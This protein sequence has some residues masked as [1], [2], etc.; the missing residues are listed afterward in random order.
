MHILKSRISRD[1]IQPPDCHA[2]RTFQTCLVAPL[3]MKPLKG[4]CRGL[5]GTARTGV[6][7]ASHDP[8]R[9][10]RPCA[11]GP[12]LQTSGLPTREP[13]RADR[14]GAQRRVRS[15]GLSSPQTRSDTRRAPLCGSS[16]PGRRSRSTG[17]SS[18]ETARFR[19]SANGSQ[20]TR[21]RS[22]TRSKRRIRWARSAVPDTGRNGTGVVLIGSVSGTE[23]V[24]A[25]DRWLTWPWTGRMQWVN[26]ACI[27]F[28]RPLPKDP[29]LVPWMSRACIAACA[30][31]TSL[32][33]SSCLCLWIQVADRVMEPREHLLFAHQKRLP[34]AFIWKTGAATS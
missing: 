7:T 17:M 13:P 32:P 12:G 18:T 27:H 8:S 10:R 22:Q 21:R 16:R 2:A 28:S 15:R 31:G 25:G 29:A 3:G 11:P 20:K 34:R 1:V 23:Y 33:P 6:E 26:H 5:S 19:S 24:P 4:S 30:S 14:S 9:R